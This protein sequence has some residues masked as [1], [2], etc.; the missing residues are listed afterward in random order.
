[1]L[2]YRKLIHFHSRLSWWDDIFINIIK[3]IYSIRS[4]QT[5]TNKNTS[6]DFNQNI[7]LTV[8]NNCDQRSILN[9][10]APDAMAHGQF[11]EQFHSFGLTDSVQLGMNGTNS[12]RYKP[13][14]YLEISNST[15]TVIL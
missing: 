13:V 8:K 12:E 4:N 14:S 10:L 11:H 9:T 3:N 2:S 1:M 6:Y 7:E 5:K 15:D